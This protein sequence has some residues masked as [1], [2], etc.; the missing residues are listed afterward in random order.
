MH[1]GTGYYEDLRDPTLDSLWERATNLA[2][3]PCGAHGPVPPSPSAPA[4]SDASVPQ[5]SVVVLPRGKA[6]WDWSRHGAIVTLTYS[7]AA[8]GTG[9]AG[10]DPSALLTRAWDFVEKGLQHQAQKRAREGASSHPPATRPR[11]DR[12]E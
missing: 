8:M 10:E 11:S 5:S 2:L 1:T 6:Q 7:P 4:L 3:S 9:W 12:E